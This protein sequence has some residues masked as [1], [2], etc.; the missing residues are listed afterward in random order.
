[1]MKYD[2]DKQFNKCMEIYPIV[3]YAMALTND[4]QVFGTV[5]TSTIKTWADDHGIDPRDFVSD[6][7]DIMNT[8]IEE[9]EDDEE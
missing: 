3:K 6:M 4:P 5:M 7:T 2:G 1:M 9:E 8:L